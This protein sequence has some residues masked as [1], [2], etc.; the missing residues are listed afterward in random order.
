[1]AAVCDDLLDTVMEKAP[2]EEASSAVLSHVP[3]F[4]YLATTDAGP[5]QVVAKDMIAKEI[6]PLLSLLFSVN[7]HEHQAHLIAKN[8][9]R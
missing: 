9:F 4:A 1:M 6:S 2:L 7:G 8:N 5:D 3:I